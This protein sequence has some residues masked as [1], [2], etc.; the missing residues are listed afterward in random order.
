MS[1]QTFRAT[2]VLTAAGL[3]LG[4][5]GQDTQ[6]TGSGDARG[7]PMEA[8]ATEPVGVGMDLPDVRVH[9]AQ[10]DPVNLQEM[11]RSKPTV[12]VWYRGRW[13]KYCRR[14]LAQVQEI[15]RELESRGYQ[16]AG[17]SPDR[18][19]ELV[20]TAH[21]EGLTFTLLSDSRGNAMRGAGLAWRVDKA[22]RNRLAGYG[23]NLE[24]A[25]G[26]SHHQLPVPSVYITGPDGLIDFAHVDP[27]YEQRLSN[28]KILQAIGAGSN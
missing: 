11:V 23:I 27:D 19:S 12:L 28:Q 24:A 14:Y 18:P 2:A 10:G 21:Q 9:N 26:Y 25:S 3:L 4:G 17:I 1:T 7:V 20:K 6:P 8:S 15:V 13:C 16:V 22:G 5:C